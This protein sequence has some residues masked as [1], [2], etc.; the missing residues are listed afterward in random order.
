[1]F[2]FLQKMPI[3]QSL[4]EDVS[5]DTAFDFKLSIILRC[6]R[7]FILT[8]TVHYVLVVKKKS[9]SWK[10]KLGIKH[11]RSTIWPMLCSL[12]FFQYFLYRE[13]AQRTVTLLRTA[14]L[15]A[16]APGETLSL[17]NQQWV[18]CTEAATW[19]SQGYQDTFTGFL[20]NLHI[21]GTVVLIIASLE[22]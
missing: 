19:P 6:Y 14:R 9:L 20:W 11:P 13:Q 22:M 3:W 17:I 5:E 2:L 12:I 8:T 21:F 18:E 16:W 15:S 7:Q 1:M 10:A 4:N